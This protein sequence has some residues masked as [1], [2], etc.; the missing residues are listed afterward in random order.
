MQANRERGG[1]VP[2]GSD[3]RAERRAVVPGQ[4]DWRV[5]GLDGANGFQVGARR[6]RVGAPRL[7]PGIPQV[8]RGTRPRLVHG[9]DEPTSEKPVAD[10][11]VRDAVADSRTGSTPLDLPCIVG[12]ALDFRRHTRTDTES[13]A[14]RGHGGPHDGGR[15]ETRPIPAEARVRMSR[16]R[17][18]AH[19]PSEQHERWKDALLGLL[20]PKLTPCTYCS[21]GLRDNHP[22]W[23]VYDERS[24]PSQFITWTCHPGGHDHLLDLL[25]GAIGAVA[26]QRLPLADGGYCIPDI[27]MLD[28]S[29][30][31]TAL[32]EVEH[33]HPPESP[34]IAARER[35]LP[36]FVVPA[37]AAWV[38][39]PGFAPPEPWVRTDIDRVLRAAADAFNRSP[40]S[41]VSRRFEYSTIEDDEGRLAFGRYVG[42]APGPTD[43]PPLHGHA[44]QARSCTWSC[45][46]AHDALKRQWGEC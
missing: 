40:G 31:P 28:A 3:D 46:R 41:D 39:T 7:P 12:I 38:L 45:D 10:R 32:L 14:P 21:V 42:S 24:R 2:D 27:A 30:E 34:L 5:R 17:T 1:L 29:G 8:R 6:I 26:E 22:P 35:D 23:H 19:M 37:P 43:L 15:P 25:G 20:R 33:T 11:A 36:L 4:H 13:P 9:R 44:I 18:L 16:S